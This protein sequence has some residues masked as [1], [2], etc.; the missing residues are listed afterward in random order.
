MTYRL[1][2]YLYHLVD[3]LL[4]CWQSS[5]W[6]CRVRLCSFSSLFKTLLLISASS[7]NT[8]PWANIRH[9]KLPGLNSARWNTSHWSFTM[10]VNITKSSS[11]FFTKFMYF[12]LLWNNVFGPN[13]S[14]SKVTVSLNSRSLVFF[15]VSFFFFVMYNLWTL[16]VQQHLVSLAQVWAFFMVGRIGTVYFVK[17]FVSTEIWQK[18]SLFFWHIVKF[19]N[20]IYNSIL[21]KKH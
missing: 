19:S 15:F 2:R 11:C 18:S 21:W 3:H 12:H 4:S 8:K 9:L 17:V 16:C 5:A 10:L 13:T 7:V 20:R 14:E 6:F 1:L